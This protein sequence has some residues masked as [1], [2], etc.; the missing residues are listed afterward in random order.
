M[1]GEATAAIE[2]TGIR[3]R[4]LM[5]PLR[6][7]LKVSFGLFKE[8]PFLAVEIETKGGIT[9]RVL[10]FTFHRLGLT[11]VP[12]VLEHLATFA[13]GKAIHA[14]DVGAFHDACQKSL[15]LLGHE[16]VMQLALSMFDMAIHDA[17]AKSAGVPLYKLLGGK[18]V[19]IPSYNSCGGSIIPPVDAAKEARE[20]VAEHGGFNHVKVRLGRASIAE[21]IAALKAIRDAVGPAVL[22]STDFN[23]ALPSSS[24]YEACH[25]VDDLG[26]TWIEEPIVFD[27]YETQARLT[28]KLRT[29]IQVGETWWHWRTG[30]RAIEMGASD[31]IMPDILRIG[32]VTGWMRLARIAEQNAVPFSSHLS[33]EFSAHVLAA[34]PT[35][36]WLEFMDWAQD[37]LVDPVVPVK[38][39]VHP[40]DKP[41]AGIEFNE[42]ALTKLVV[43]A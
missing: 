1:T 32:G 34:T 22:L 6:R 31:Y 27:D 13:K 19:A 3:I 29:P 28:A 41:G 11:L 43:N 2:I 23:Q 18:S 8:G 15:M 17:L 16:G 14:A 10:G 40:S 21:D 36:H 37:L 5:V 4:R 7:P 42:G 38:G 25:A 30:K 12:P 26:L 33:P 24:A 39:M 35:R 9:G 20:L